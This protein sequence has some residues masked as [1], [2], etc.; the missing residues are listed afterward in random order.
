M[1]SKLK[2]VG[3]IFRSPLGKGMVVV[4]GGFVF[5]LD[6]IW[7]YDSERRLPW[8]NASMKSSCKAFFSISD[9]GERGHCRWCHPWASSP[10]FYKKASWA[11]QEKQSSK[12]HPSIPLHQLLSSSSCPVWVPALTSFGD[13]QQCGSVS[14]INPFLLNLL[15]GHDVFCRNT[16]LDWDST[17]ETQLSSLWLFCPS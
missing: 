9:Q 10:G 8:G 5:Q 17:W 1:W 4:L 7:S 16:K 14:W 2:S 12:Q 15:L 11:S 3:G 6:T 13:E